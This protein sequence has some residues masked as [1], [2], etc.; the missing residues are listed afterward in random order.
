MYY[1]NNSSSC[2]EFREDSDCNSNS[3]DSPYIWVAYSADD[4]WGDGDTLRYYSA[5]N[6]DSFSDQDKNDGI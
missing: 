1:K 6:Y 4:W 3:S 2:T 5:D